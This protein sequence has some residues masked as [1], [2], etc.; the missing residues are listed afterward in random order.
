M[1]YLR[2]GIF[3]SWLLAFTRARFACAKSVRVQISL[4]SFPY[5]VGVLAPIGLHAVLLV[6]L[7]RRGSLCCERPEES[8]S[9][10]DGVA[11]GSMSTK[12]ST[13]TNA[14]AAM[15]TNLRLRKGHQFANDV[16]VPAASDEVHGCANGHQPKPMLLSPHENDEGDGQERLRAAAAPFT[17]RQKRANKQR[18]A[19]EK[20]GERFCRVH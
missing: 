8:R 4:A 9:L 7:S 17:R 5:S 15:A 2:V 13:T 6:E 12:S 1:A 10:L 20:R 3:A 19:T 11:G 14:P 16:Q 18:R